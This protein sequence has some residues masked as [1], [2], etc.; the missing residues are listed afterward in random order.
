MATYEEE[1]RLKL[2]YDASAVTV[3]TQRMM[4]AQKKSALDYVT[5]WKKSIN[6]VEQAQISADVRAASRANQ[7]ARLNRERAEVQAQR[8]KAINEEIAR[9]YVPD[10]MRGPGG[11]GG[12]R[13][14]GAGNAAANAAGYIANETS[15]SG[16]GQTLFHVLNVGGA[17]SSIALLFKQLA[18][19]KWVETIA[20]VG[21]GLKKYGSKILEHAGFLAR[22]SGV[23]TAAV[24]TG[25]IFLRGH[26]MN[27]AIKE[28]SDSSSALT[29]QSKALGQRLGLGD[30]ASTAA[31]AAKQREMRWAL[32][33]EKKALE[34]AKEKE[35]T[36][37]RQTAWQDKF[38]RLQE[39]QNTLNREA[40]AL[41]KQER[42]LAHSIA[43]IDVEHLTVAQLA[44]RQ[45]AAAI[46]AQF[47]E[48]GQ[49]DIESGTGPFAKAAAEALFYKGKQGYDISQG[50]AVWKQTENGPE[51]VGGAAFEDRRRQIAA[52]NTLWQ[53]GLETPAMQ[54][55]AMLENMFVLNSNMKVL[56]D[57][58]AGLGLKIYVPDDGTP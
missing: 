9:G 55:K 33:E 31:V 7:A 14:A 5:F 12:S 4:D 28:S 58:A 6:D 50:N 32:D 51:L 27:K 37:K 41:R 39:E 13:A 45:A 35:A 43:D 30:N 18:G 34:L 46:A 1:I 23:L 2:G 44:G 19:V 26:Q 25:D 16:I 52:E 8:Q 15:G 17:L 42:G 49:F 24:L 21:I 20:H 36:L 56:S 47:G 57:Q 22:A 48:G 3:G 38:N 40:R 54:Q 29:A 11:K 53:A 10:N